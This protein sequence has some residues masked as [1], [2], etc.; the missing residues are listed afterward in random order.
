VTPLRVVRSGLLHPFDNMALDEA[1]L[2]ETGPPTLRLYGWSPAAVS[3]GRFQDAAAFRAL[4]GAPLL[5][6]RITGGGAIHHD[7]E[8]TFALALASDLLPESIDASYARIHDAVARALARA[9]VPAQRRMG[10]ASCARGADAFCF[11]KPA[12]ND[13]VTPAG[14]KLV[15]SAQRRSRGRILHHGSVPLRRPRATPWAGAVE[16]YADPDEVRELL[17]AGL[18]EELGKA[19]G[20][21]PVAGV[22][23]ARELAT[24][25]R[26]R[27]ASRARASAS[28]R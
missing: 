27:G 22:L 19:L 23:G 18:A 8:L 7:D 14:R 16:D 15:G 2:V 4:P 1:L 24:A 6:R 9:G 20:L 10:G 3:L 13:L 11:E 25:A 12:R 21:D 26:L 17:T 28:A 5:V